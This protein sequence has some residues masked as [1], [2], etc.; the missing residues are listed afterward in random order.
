MWKI[1]SGLSPLKH[2][3]S[4]TGFLRRLPCRAFER[5]LNTSGTTSIHSVSRISPTATSWNDGNSPSVFSRISSL[6][7]DHCC[8]CNIPPAASRLGHLRILE[9]SAC[10]MFIYAV[11]HTDPHF[12]QVLEVLEITST[13]G[14]D[15]YYHRP[16]DFR[17]RIRKCTNL[18]EFRAV[19]GSGGVGREGCCS[20][21]LA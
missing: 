2:L 17:D 1:L 7:L 18:R 19:A 15:L 12:A 13:N 21:S 16:Q 14:C 10:D 20:Y 8:G 6:T 5:S 11:D 3:E 4:V 9:N